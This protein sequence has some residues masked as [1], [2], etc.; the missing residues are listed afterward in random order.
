MLFGGFGLLMTFLKRYAFSAIGMTMFLTVLATEW[1]VVLSGM[2]K[3]GDDFVVGLDLIHLLE[4]GVA[5]AAV[6][7]T[8]GAV[9]GK[10]NPLQLLAVCLVETTLFTAN[11]HIG[12]SVLGTADVGGAI[13]VHAFGAY[14][15]LALAWIARP[16]AP[17]RSNHRESSV[18]ISDV[19]AAAGTIILWVFWPSFNGALASTP[20]ALH[21]AILNTYL[22]LAGSTVAAFVISSLYGE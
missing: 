13:F 22:S 3:M 19:S 4:G 8:F 21:R 1:Y 7:I 2:L 10:L 5:A 17:G 20:D 18:Y 15:G 6:L 11:A 14:F 9:L 12:Y 16:T